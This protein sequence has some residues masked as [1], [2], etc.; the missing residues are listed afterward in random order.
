MEI[1][2]KMSFILHLLNALPALNVQ[3]PAVIHYAECQV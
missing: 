2:N 3:P 1:N